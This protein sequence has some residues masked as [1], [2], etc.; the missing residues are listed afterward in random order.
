MSTFLRQILPRGDRPEPIPPGIYQTAGLEVDEQPYRF[1]LRIE[2][3]GSGLLLVN[4]AIALHLNPSAA[5]HAYYFVSGLSE[6]AAA[7]SIADRYRVSREQALSDQV[8][9]RE[10]V[11]TLAVNPEVDPVVYLGLDRTEPY[12]KT[13]S[14]P[15]RLDLA[16]TYACDPEGELDPLARKRV[17]RELES[18]E[19]K[20]ILSAAWEAGIPHVTFTGGE[21]TR[22]DDLIELIRH[23]EELGQ[24]SGLLTNGR[25]LAQATY[26]DSLAQTGLD[27][28]LVAVEPEDD[29]SQDGLRAALD[30]EI[31]TAAHFTIDPDSAE[32]AMALLE[33]FAAAGLSAVS[34]SSGSSAQTAMQLLAA[35]GERAADLDMEL[36]WDMPAPFS[37]T[38]PIALELEDPPQ[39][40]GRAWLYVEPDGDVLPAQGVD[41]VLGNM[42]RD[43]WAAIWNKATSD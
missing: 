16:L 42:L 35:A 1:H 38:N 31:F 24:L 22:R 34:L 6:E 3:D 25:R 27:H 19:W 11:L 8:S 32:S 23:A 40:A 43:P 28:I 20:Q 14:A 9:L 2:P 13:P 36:I 10:Q 7:T 33:E 17:D 21:P 18:G 5:E 12:S 4:A 29:A 39:G 26:L 41:R 37:M 15:Y 30:S